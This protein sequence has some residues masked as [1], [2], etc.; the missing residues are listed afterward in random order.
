MCHLSLGHE[1]KA[2]LTFSLIFYFSDILFL[3]LCGIVIAAHYC[4]SA[5]RCFVLVVVLFV[6]FFL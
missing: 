1:K 2:L 6:C 5:W 4:I 3:N